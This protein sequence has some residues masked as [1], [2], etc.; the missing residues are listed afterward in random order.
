MVVGME[1]VFASAEGADQHEQGGLREVE[2]GEHG[3]HCLEFEAGVDEEVGSGGTRE[4]GSC[5]EAN[6]MFEGAD[7]GGTDGDDAARGEES[8]IDRGGCGGGNGIRFGMKFVILDALDV[9][10]LK[11]SEADVQ[12]DLDGLDF[13]LADAV[14]DLRGEVETGGRGGD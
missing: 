14:K 4:N 1:D 10:G 7:G 3:A 2:I 6:R 12:G 9:D 11:R 8:L 13:A 5:A